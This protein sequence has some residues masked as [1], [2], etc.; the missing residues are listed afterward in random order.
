MGVFAHVLL[1]TDFSEASAGAIERA[2]AVARDAGAA[3]T[4]VHACEIPVLP[5]AIPPLDLVNKAIADAQPRLDRLLATIRDACPAA[6][7]VVKI[8]AAWEGILE[9]AA[10]TG[11][12]LVVVGSHGRRGLVHALLGSVA[13]RVVRL[14]TVPVLVVRPP[15][16]R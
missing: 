9:A 8:G 5:E 15:A 1:A 7:G 6:R 3:L 14:S 2:V 4:V 12:D 11:A 16:A 13:E 10:E